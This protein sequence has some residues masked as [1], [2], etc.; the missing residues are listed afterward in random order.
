[1]GIEQRE[2]SYVE[3]MLAATAVGSTLLAFLALSHTKR[4]MAT[5]VSKS[6]RPTFQ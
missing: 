6:R 5:H 4:C 3:S 1:M 2:G